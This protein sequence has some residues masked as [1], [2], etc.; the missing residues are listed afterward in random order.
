MK[1]WNMIVDVALCHDCNNC[2]LACKDEYVGND[3][4]GYSVAQPW[5]G[6]R[7]M[8]ILRKERG[9][10]PMV[11]VAFLPKPCQ[12]CEDAPCITKDGA[13]YKRKDG[14]VIIDPKKA[15]GQKQIVSSC[16]YGVIYWNEEAGLPQKCTGCAHLIDDGWT[17]TRCTQVCPTGALKLV[18]GDEDEMAIKASA[19]GLEAYEA[20][21]G[22]NPRVWYKNLHRWT[23]A[24]L[25]GTVAYK[26][27]DDCAE[28]AVV[29]LQSAGVKVADVAT[30]NYGDFIFDDLP[31]G[32][33]DLVISAAGYK[34]VALQ[35]EIV[36][37]LNLGVI[38]VEK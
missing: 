34:P 11:Q 10:Y 15:K 37:S 27:T 17:E 35:A 36:D 19:E 16:P 5:S 25:G 6:Q 1:K 20:D 31:P 3:F 12:H 4:K 9:Q 38:F 33:Y 29:I 2:F 30:N 23:K 28:G 14:L 8:D 24:F 13:V 26:D 32:T 7:W 22:T 18:L 21:W